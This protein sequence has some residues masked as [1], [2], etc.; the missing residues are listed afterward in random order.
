MMKDIRVLVVDDHQIVRD[1]LESLLGRVDDIELVGK[2]ANSKEALSE[3]KRLSTDVV[4][5][6]VK[7]PDM[8]GV[9]R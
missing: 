6:D 5:M 8:D 7:M 2:A 4:L 3:L 9:S 1:G